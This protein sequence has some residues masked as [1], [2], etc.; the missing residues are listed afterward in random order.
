[1]GQFPSRVTEE[2]VGRGAEGS[3]ELFLSRARKK[4]PKLSYSVLGAP[5]RGQRR[6]RK[7]RRGVDD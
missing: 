6:R 1:M 3:I 7:R 4:C 5:R 2:V